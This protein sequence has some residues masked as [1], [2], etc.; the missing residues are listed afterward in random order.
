MHFSL[1]SELV[2]LK[3]KISREFLN[4]RYLCLKNSNLLQRYFDAVLSLT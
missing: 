3:V 2:L 1:T 4:K